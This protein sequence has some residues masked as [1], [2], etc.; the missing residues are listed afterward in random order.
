M[1]QMAQKMRK[2]MAKKDKVTQRHKGIE[3]ESAKIE[4]QKKKVT[5]N[6]VCVFW[7]ESVSQFI[8]IILFWRTRYFVLALQIERQCVDGYKLQ[9]TL[10]F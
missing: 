3:I 6:A 5:K 7:D 8:L 4:E 1:D 2:H 9:L 10:C